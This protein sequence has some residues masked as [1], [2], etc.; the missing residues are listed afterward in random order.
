VLLVPTGE[1]EFEA[2]AKQLYL[3]VCLNIKEED[4]VV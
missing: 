4:I 3:E 2:L 1:L